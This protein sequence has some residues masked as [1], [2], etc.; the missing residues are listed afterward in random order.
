MNLRTSRTLVKRKATKQTARK[1][2]TASSP[3][4][5]LS[6]S[7]NACTASMCS[8]GTGS[9]T[10]LERLWAEIRVLLTSMHSQCWK[11]NRITTAI[12]CQ[13]PRKIIWFTRVKCA[14]SGTVSAEL[15]KRSLR[16]FPF[17]DMKMLK[18]T[19]LCCMD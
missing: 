12:L 3:L 13:C 4:G 19:E 2:D 9:A 5:L 6:T 14:E 7:S 17:R 1:V 8:L 18:R 15:L 16:K 11:D 10:R